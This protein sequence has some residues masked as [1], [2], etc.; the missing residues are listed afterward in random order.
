V[1]VGKNKLGNRLAQEIQR[2]QIGYEVLGFVDDNPA[3]MPEVTLPVLGTVDN[4]KKLIGE[5]GINEV[6]LALPNAPR[7]RLMKLVEIC[8]G[9]KVSWK[10]VPDFYEVMLD[11]V[12]VDSLDGIPLI[13]MKRSNIFGLNALIKRVID[14]VC[15]TILLIVFGLP[16]LV[17]TLL[18]KITSAGPVLY[19]QKRIGQDGKRFVFLKFRSMY[20]KVRPT[21]HKEFTAG[22]IKEEDQ[23]TASESA[24]TSAPANPEPLPVQDKPAPPDKKI[25][26]LQY[27]PRIT[28]VG[29]MLRKFSLDELPQLFNVLSGDISLIGPRP[30]LAYEVERY[31]EWHKRR[32]EAKPGLT[33]LWQ[34]SGRNLLSFEEMVKLDIYYI[35]N[36]SLWLDLEILF[37][38]IFVVLFGKT[39]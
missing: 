36:W 26:K 22:W 3:P 38:T 19:K 15:V 17:I 32:L 13:G 2:R 30:P 20:P 16:M 18:V 21:A 6:W 25:Y 10:M 4:L 33:G 23:K 39:Y 7:E 12:K 5:R 29:R 14:L 8:L 31:K 11:W 34:V 24:L 9:T 1:I 28:P 27:D 37:K 35:E